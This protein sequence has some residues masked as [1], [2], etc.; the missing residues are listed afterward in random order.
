M[1]V[2]RSVQ[3]WCRRTLSVQ[4]CR[5]DNLHSIICRQIRSA[6]PMSVAEYM[7]LAM[8]HPV[9]G[10]YKKSE[11]V[12]PGGDFITSPEISQ[13]FGELLGVWIVNEWMNLNKNAPFD[14][15]E[16]GP[17]SGALIATILKTLCKFPTGSSLFRR[18]HL[19]ERSD[20]LRQKQETV[21]YPLLKTLHLKPEVKWHSSI[22]DV[23]RGCST[24]YLAHEFLDALPVHRFQLVDGKW[25][26]VFV[27]AVNPVNPNELGD[28]LSFFVSR[29]LTM[30][31]E[32]YLPLAGDLSGKNCVEVCP[33]AG[34]IVQK[35]AARI[36]ADGGAALVIDYGHCGEK[37]DTLRGPR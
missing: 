7:K 15:V 28:Q 16:F 12:G 2:I 30:A 10:Y 17:G 5:S 14:I 18:L 35:L 29:S 20:Y 36:A 11:V 33:E 1:R 4:A 6:G 37:G 19:I 23:P 24:Y 8:H 22:D 31:C 32:T 3:H 13:V 34:A 27:N 9:Y 25:R 26:E 21:I